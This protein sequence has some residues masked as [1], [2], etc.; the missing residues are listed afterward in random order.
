MNLSP[1]AAVIV[2]QQILTAETVCAAGGCTN[3]AAG[4]GMPVEP[5]MSPP[6]T[7]FGTLN[8][9]RPYCS[10]HGRNSVGFR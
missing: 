3:P 10:A 5:V 7:A 8:G 6:G 9:V 2:R 4:T 1:L